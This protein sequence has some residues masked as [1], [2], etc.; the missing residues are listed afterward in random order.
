MI[1][2]LTTAGGVLLLCLTFYLPSFGQDPIFSQF[3]NTPLH[4]NPAYVGINGGVVGTTT[5][6]RQWN[7]IPGGFNT[8]YASL[9]T[10]EPCLPGAIGFSVMRD[11]EGEGLLTT[12]AANAYVGF[13][14]RAETRKAVHNWRLAVSPYWMEKRIDWERLVFSDQLD[15]RYGAIFASNFRPENY[16]PARFG[17]MNF[18]YVHRIDIRNGD[19]EDIQLDYGIGLNNLLNFSLNTGPVESLQG[20]D[21]GIPLRWTAHASIY[22][23][24]LSIG[25]GSINRF[26]LVPQVR[27]EGQ[28]GLS[29]V[30]LGA[31][32]IYQGGTIGFYYH[33]RQPLAGFADTDA[34]IA[35]IGLG[36]DI[37]KRQAL[38][39]GISYDVNVG[40]LRSMSG[41][42][43]ELNV[44]YFLQNGGLFCNAFSGGAKANGRR[45]R[46]AVQ[47]PP[48]G[49]SHHRRWNN[50]WY[51]N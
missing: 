31:A 22:L 28:G 35:Y 51:R 27:V 8:M 6:R 43:L 34:L 47:C 33:N 48:V 12:T 30:T 23:P 24:M 50:I 4:L 49:R 36:I 38:E 19:K 18:G 46:G 25:E 26:R 7:E 16:A 3:F 29:A 9:E 17:G 42:V 37:D 2:Y 1:R 11:S 45:R 13:I 10:Y 5:Y 20:L 41:G 15:A 39:I 21:T 40:G 14:A 32:G 44:R